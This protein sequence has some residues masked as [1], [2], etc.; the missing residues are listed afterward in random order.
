VFERHEPNVGII[1]DA[2]TEAEA[3][4][5]V[6]VAQELRRAYPEATLVIVPKC[7]AAFDVIPDWV[8]LGYPAGSHAGKA[9]HTPEEYSALADWRG[10]RLHLLGGAPQR[11]WTLI[12]DLTQPTLTGLEPANIVGMDYNGFFANALRYGDVW[13]PTQ[14]H[15]RTYD[16]SS[17]R[18]R[19]R[20]SLEHAKAYWQQRGVWATHEDQSAVL[21]PDD[22]VFATRGTPFDPTES[23]LFECEFGQAAGD[24][25]R[26][27]LVEYDDGTVLAYTSQK[28]RRFL[29]HRAGVRREYGHPQR[30]RA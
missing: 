26:G 8:V 27:V 14:P 9:D 5:Y 1:G 22:P 19:V 23:E 18:E 11:R 21:E 28:H 13:H 20:M 15:W 29:E 30:V 2:F 25:G 3:R 17:L 12:Q 4:E 24:E 10:R 7:E 6:E 16:D